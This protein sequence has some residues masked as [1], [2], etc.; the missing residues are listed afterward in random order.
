VKI[1]KSFDS[2]IFTG[3]TIESAVVNIDSIVTIDQVVNA[4]PVQRYQ[5]DKPQPGTEN[6]MDLMKSSAAQN[7]SIHH[8][9]GVDKLHAA[10]LKGKGVTVAIVDSGI[11]YYHPAVRSISGLTKLTNWANRIASLEVAMVALGAGFSV[12]MTSAVTCVGLW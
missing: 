5:L 8:L 4:W 10:G 3:L 1:T 7:Y 6:D 9:T 12:A 11:D 2:P